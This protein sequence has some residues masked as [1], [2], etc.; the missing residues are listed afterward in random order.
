MSEESPK[1][2]FKYSDNGKVII[3]EVRGKVSFSD[4]Y[5][6]WLE[7]IEKE[8]INSSV[9]GLINDFRGAD[10]DVNITD[11][12]KIL[13]LLSDNKELFKGIKIAVI[14]DSYK[15]I[16]YPMLIEKISEESV[17]PFSTFDAAYDW[18]MGIL[19]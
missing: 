15:N 6:S 11:T 3:R 14:V 12:Q 13:S 19:D 4:V 17:K 2:K 10:M 18:I 9:I 7:L 8:A 5:K 1:I 16:V